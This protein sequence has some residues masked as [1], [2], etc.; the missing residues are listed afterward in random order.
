MND[1]VLLRYMSH[2]AGYGN[3]DSDYWMIGMEEGGGDTIENI[4]K[5]I[6]IWEES[7]QNTLEDLKLYHDKIGV[8]RWFG[9][10]AKLQPTWNKLIRI[11]HGIKGLT[12]NTEDV[13]TYQ[14]TH[15]GRSNGETCLAELMPLPSPSTNHW[16]YPRISSLS[17]LRTRKDY[18]RH[19]GPIRLQILANLINIHRPKNVVFYGSGYYQDWWSQLMPE[20]HKAITIEGVKAY[21]GED[22]GTVFS[23]SPHPVATGVKNT[24]F[25]GLGSAMQEARS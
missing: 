12:P 11:I 1:D 6:T 24:F 17:E 18:M 3:L 2:F 13:R 10:Q 7:G 25:H 15:L 14:K 4:E 21:L 5:R 23:V 9:S 16:L 19:W 20:N 8:T 22:E